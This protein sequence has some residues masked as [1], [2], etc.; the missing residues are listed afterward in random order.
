MTI[1]SSYKIIADH[2]RSTVFLIA[3]GVMPSNEG[4]GYVL[5]RIM[6]RAMMHIHKLNSK[7][8]KMHKLV[9]NFIKKM[10]KPYPY[11]LKTEELVTETI[12]IEEERFSKT[13][14][15]GLEI[16]EK[17]VSNITDKKN[18][19]GKIAFKLYDTYGFP[20]DLTQTILDERNIKVN[21]DEFESEMEIQKERARGN[22]KGSGVKSDNNIY[23]ELQE[24]F[25][26]TEFLGYEEV[27]S[28]AKI[29]A[30][31]KDGQKIDKIVK[32]DR[33][34]EIILEKTPFYATSGGQKGDDGNIILLSEIK[35]SQ[36]IS[37]SDL[38][39][40]IDIFE[41]K[42]FSNGI[43]SHFVSEVRGEFRVGDE[44]LALVNSRDRQFRS[45]NH[46]A[47]HLLH[48]VLRKILGD[49][50]TQKGSNVDI[51]SLTFDFNHNQSL[52]FEELIAVED[53]VNFYIRQNSE[54][55]T[56]IMDIKDATKEGAMML[57]DEKYDNQVRVLSM[58]LD[59]ENSISIELC[60]G[61]HVK[62]P[63]HM[64]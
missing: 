53:L 35:D 22:W 40:V 58:G 19:S 11:L 41:T 55:Q 51:K 57:F 46:S 15:N 62:N 30:I 4:R 6:R 17:E 60:G 21:V 13:L 29:M 49:H 5:R 28:E 26:V 47:T 7:D 45:Q 18:L 50:I 10:S 52:S 36:L 42:K 27:K 37:Y 61:S 25:G 33:N 32:N 63:G 38:S 2:L 9:A 44:V 39:N 23:F 43:F 48:F 24:E 12:R 34:V 31:I 20:L 1:N 16:L 64:G 14:K 56:K 8:L 3:D 59:N 54:V